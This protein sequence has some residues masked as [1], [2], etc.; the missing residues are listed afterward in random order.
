M[1]HCGVR[2]PLR[3]WL[4]PFGAKTK[5]DDGEPMGKKEMESPVTPALYCNPNDKSQI[6]HLGCQQTERTT[7]Q[8]YGL[9]QARR[10]TDTHAD[11]QVYVQPK[12]PRHLS[13]AT[14][15]SRRLRLAALG[16]WPS[17]AFSLGSFGLEKRG[18]QWDRFAAKELLVALAKT[19]A[20]RV[21][22]ANAKILWLSG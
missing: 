9:Y 18:A 8:L 2:T 1:T 12:S 5:R 6:W 19:P 10:V 17:C 22:L 20:P 14:A 15:P 7:A 21:A 3:S 13:L 11:T 4:L 16:A